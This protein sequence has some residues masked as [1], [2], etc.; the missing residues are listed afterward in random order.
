MFWILEITVG[1]NFAIA[2]AEQAEDLALKKKD[3]QEDE[4][5]KLKSFITDEPTALF[6]ESA[7]TESEFHF[8]I[9][10]KIGNAEYNIKDL[11]GTD[12]KPFDKTSAQKMFD[13]AK[14]I[15]E[16]KKEPAPNA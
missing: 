3:V 1:A 10:Q 2:I 15:K 13:S 7:I 14:G 6:W 12:A 8:L 11:S 9:N 4:V 5:N 16:V